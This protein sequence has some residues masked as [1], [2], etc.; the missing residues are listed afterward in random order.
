MIANNIGINEKGH[1]TFAGQ[2]TVALAE[3]YGTPL[4]LMDEN[5]IRQH[6]RTYKNAMAKYMPKGSMPEFASKAFSCKQ[7]YRIMAEEG[8]DY[9]INYA[10]LAH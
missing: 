4:Y 1:L 7:I 5:K 9:N 3:K 6:V 8:I 2:D 10:I